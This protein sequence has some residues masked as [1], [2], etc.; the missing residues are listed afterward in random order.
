[1]SVPAN[2]L[3]HRIR[4]VNSDKMNLNSYIYFNVLMSFMLLTTTAI[5]DSPAYIAQPE[6]FGSQA[7]VTQLPKTAR[8]RVAVQTRPSQGQQQAVQHAVSERSSRQESVVRQRP[9]DQLPHVRDG[10]RITQF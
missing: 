8:P 7:Y 5:A 10:I 3:L 6:H 1:M 9:I 4:T 2:S